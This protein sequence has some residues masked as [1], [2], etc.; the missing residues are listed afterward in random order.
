MFFKYIDNS[1]LFTN[2]KI[3]PTLDI[4]KEYGIDIWESFKSYY[5]KQPIL[6]KEIIKKY[7]N[8]F[9]EKYVSELED[10]SI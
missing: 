7:E 2:R 9:N 3:I 5:K 8:I 6:N 10:F 1:I 4:L